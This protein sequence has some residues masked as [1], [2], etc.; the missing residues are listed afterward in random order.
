MIPTIGPYL[1]PILLPSLRHG[2]PEAE[3]SLAETVTEQLEARLLAGELDAAILATAPGNPRLAEIP[4]FDEPFW[5]ALP[6]GHALQDREEIALGELECDELLLLEDGHC[7]SDQILSFCGQAF[8]QSPRASTRHTSLM[9]VTALVG[10]GIGVTLV[11]AL[12]L[13]GSW[14][15]D[16]GVVLRKES[17]RRARRSVRLVFRTAFPRRQLIDKLA[18][19]LC[20]IV[21]DTVTPA[22]R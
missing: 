18:D 20:A 6:K 16:S 15:T 14:V 1:T 21:P 17:S 4:L 9:T 5:I 8:T 22:R 2:L 3:V 10:A 13:A 12:S 19:I 7:L 11:P